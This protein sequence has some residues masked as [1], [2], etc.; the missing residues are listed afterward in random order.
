MHGANGAGGVLNHLAREPERLLAS[1]IGVFQQTAQFR[2]DLLQGRLERRAIGH[3]FPFPAGAA[4]FL[5]FVASFALLSALDLA[6]SL[7]S[8]P[9]LSSSLSSCDRNL[10]CPPVPSSV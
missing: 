8:V 3:G 2:R 4:P 10:K 1:A 7:A 6:L 5:S 9:A